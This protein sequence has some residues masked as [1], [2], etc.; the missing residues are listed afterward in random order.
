MESGSQELSRI[1]TAYVASVAFGLSFFVAT[2]C[3]A[4]GLTALGRG[5]VV[6]LLAM[7]GGRLLTTPVVNVVL[8]ALARDQAKKQEA[9]QPR[10]EP[11]K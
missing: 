4:D 9:A 2:A 8:D 7:L 1:A 3:G 10:Q 11:V 5:A 6:V